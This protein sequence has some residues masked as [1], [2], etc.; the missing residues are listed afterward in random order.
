MYKQLITGAILLA[1]QFVSAQQLNQAS[2]QQRVDYVIHV[3]LD[4]TLHVLRA[5]EIMTYHNESPNT[6]NE[7]YIHLWPNAYLNNETPF[8]KQQAENGKNDFCSADKE[9]RGRMDSLSFKVNGE[10]VKWEFQNGQYEICKL[11]LNKP[12][13]PDDKIEISTPFRVKLPKVFSRLGHEGQMYCITQWYPKPA[14]YD[15]NGWNPMPYLDQ[16]EFYSE[17][18]KFDVSITVPENYMVA[19]TGNLQ[20]ANELEKM[21]RL[22]E[23]KFIKTECRKDDVPPSSATTK[24]LRYVQDNVH[25]FAWFADKRFKVERSEVTLGNGHKVITWLFE[26]CPKKSGVH[27]LDT[28]IL[29][30]S[31]KV[32]NYPYDNATAVV[33]PLK[34][35]AGMEYPTITNVEEAGREVIVHEVGH[36]WFYGILATNERMYPWMD[37]SINNY[38]E[39]RSTYSPKV[40]EHGGLLAGLRKTGTFNTESVA[41]SSFGVLE[42]EYL[43]SARNNTDQKIFIPSEAFT[44]MN[45]GTMVYGKAALAFHQLQ[46]YLGDE[47]FDGMMRSYFDKWKFRHPLPNDFIDHAKSYTGKDLNWF[48]NG[49]MNTEYEPDYAISA[50]KR[51]GDQLR[52]T[53]KN[54]G[55]VAAPIALQTLN[56]EAI[57]N[58]VKLEPFEKDTTV[59]LPLSNATHVRLDAR[60]ESIDVYRGNNYATTKGLF[61]TCRPVEFNIIANLEKPQKR[62]VFYSPIAGA[63]LYNKTML[64]LAF[65]NSIF[66]RQKTEYILAPMYAFG[67]KDLAGYFSLQRRFLT[68][69]FVKEIQVGVD[70]ARF[71][72]HGD[73]PQFFYDSST[74]SNIEGVDLDNKLRVYEKVA[75]RIS[76]LFKKG[77]PRTDADKKL[78]LRY[79]MA[80]EQKF[81]K[82]L[83]KDFK[84]HYGYVDV[85]YALEQKRMLNP[86]SFFANYQYGQ[87]QGT[88]QKLTMEL[89]LFLD[90]GEKKRNKG[91]T[92]RAFA[93]AFIQKPVK[94]KDERIEFRAAENNGYYDYMYDQ[95]QFGRGNSESMFMQQVMPNTSGFRTYAQG[96]GNTDSWLASLNFTSTIPGVLPIRPFV[97]VMIINAKQYTSSTVG[98]V[99]TY[100]TRYEANLHY[101]AGVSVWIFKDIFHVNF[102]IY[103]DIKTTDIWKNTQ[104]A[105][106]QRMTFTLKLNLLNP[107]KQVREAK[108]F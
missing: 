53:V 63:N 90:Y 3:S 91:L 54:K 48:F 43:L 74:N 50:V 98:G 89:N 61:K 2:W 33:T 14:V 59:I 103:A 70:A 96:L 75:P 49:L 93:G 24:T 8:A 106:G 41:S 72:M 30:Y 105:Y 4:D 27:L 77:N 25:D 9:E 21:K 28:A 46:A 13:F 79:V 16:G 38:Y 47:V 56:N 36:N 45:Y 39:S 44:D 81:T 100:D 65:Y 34:A 104:N 42:L 22:S 1:S 85:Q 32:G 19:A 6:L 80:Y 5:H 94:G 12:L 68:Q 23:T 101:L 58:E 51:T 76:F 29:F 62:Q 31:D 17:F 52:I 102:P 82:E 99:T 37:E 71:A 107:V 18:G 20:N 10:N 40:A 78:T 108:L 26:V 92:V 55:K 95:S 60:E 69:G 84:N 97:D 88:F 86:Y 57:V 15:V 64:G 67:T 83:F 11:T 66:P 87:A 35:G 73:N 7:I